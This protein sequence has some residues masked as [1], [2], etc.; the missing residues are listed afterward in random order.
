MSNQDTNSKLFQSAE[1]SDVV[2]ALIPMWEKRKASH[3]EGGR[4]KKTLLHLEIEFFLGAVAALDQLNKFNDPN[5]KYS[6]LPPRVFV[7]ATRGESIVES[8]SK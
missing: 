3:I 4:T 1:A 5:L 2:K 6:C 8:Y 7:A